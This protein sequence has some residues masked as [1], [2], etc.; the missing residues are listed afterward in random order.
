MEIGQR[1]VFNDIPYAIK[2]TFFRTPGSKKQRLVS[3]SERDAIVEQGRIFYF[4]ESNGKKYFV[5]HYV[6][7]DHGICG[8]ANYEYNRMLNYKPHGGVA[9][10]KVYACENNMILM[11]YCDG[12]KMSECY[13]NFRPETKKKILAMIRSW[14]DKTGIADYDLSPNNIL[15]DVDGD[16][17]N[18]KLIDFES[19]GDC[20]KDMWKYFRGR[21]AEIS[22]NLF[23]GNGQ[24]AGLYNI[25]FDIKDGDKVLDVGSG[26]K[27]FPQATHLIDMPDTKGQRH[28]KDLKIDGRTLIEGDVCDVLGDFP[29][30]HFDFCYS[31][32][33]FEHIKDLP[34]ALEL[35]SAKC[36]RGFYALPGSDFEFLTTEDH[37]GHVNLCRQIGNTLHI[38][39]RLPST[40]IDRLGKIYGKIANANLDGFL[41]M[42]EN[43]FRFI[44]EIRHYWE[45][46]INYAVYGNPIDLFPQIK[47]F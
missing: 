42:W 8:D 19:T 22:L 14:V 12:K 46:G 1:L 5:K 35:I 18:I 44:W 20:I 6:D 17:I 4:V 43:E 45:D 3:V 33:T 39:K 24:Y 37:F 13:Q 41:D 29:D 25:D 7:P 15:I 38:A 32:H 9:P 16:N 30:K 34:K 27:P 11:E 40:V 28:G 26:N 36:K 2:D 23:L 47:Y 31:S 21:V 10:A